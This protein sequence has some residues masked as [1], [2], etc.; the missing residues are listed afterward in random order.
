[1][2]PGVT[3]ETADSLSLEKIEPII[4]ALRHER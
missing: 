3:E 2:T 1:M 4:D